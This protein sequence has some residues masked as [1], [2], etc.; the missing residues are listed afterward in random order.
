[1]TQQTPNRREVGR[2]VTVATAS[3][4]IKVFFPKLVSV[5]FEKTGEVDAQG[6]EVTKLKETLPVLP[7]CRIMGYATT[8]KPGV[9]EFGEFIK[10]G[11]QFRGTNLA[12]GEQTDAPQCILPN[13]IGEGLFAA[14]QNPARNG[15]VQ[16]AIEV[17]AKYD[18]T[19]IAKYVFIVNDLMP[20]TEHDP[21]AML[22]TSVNTGK[23][24][25]ALSAPA[26]AAALPPATPAPTQ[27]PAPAPTQAPARRR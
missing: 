11:G 1:M 22:E 6:I 24:L 16:F 7:L 14:I 10:F 13:F 26:P 20:K 15:P 5:S 3:G 21:L 2:K 25:G 17:G 8:A 18:D 4:G 19:A 9:S 23:P 27:A 12:T